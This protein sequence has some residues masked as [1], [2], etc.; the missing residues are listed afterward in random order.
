MTHTYCDASWN[1]EHQDMR[2][3]AEQSA[4]RGRA[5][6]GGEGR[7]DCNLMGPLNLHPFL[8]PTYLTYTQ[9]NGVITYTTLPIMLK[10]VVPGDERGR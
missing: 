5:V 4:Q 6:R 1:T 8:P 10:P 7:E 9:A 3:E 2:E